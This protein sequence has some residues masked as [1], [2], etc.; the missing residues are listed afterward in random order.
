MKNKLIAVLISAVVAFGLWLYVVTVVSPESEKTYYDIPVVLQ[1]KDILSERG[2][3]I[4]S[5]EPKVTLALRS[6]RTILN[7]LNE[8]NINVIASVANI[9]K[10]GIHTLTY[11]VA[12]PGNV[13][14]N[15]VSVQSSSTDLITLEVENRVRKTVPVVI[16]FG[17]TTVPEGYIA[18]LKN[19]NLDYPTIE[20][21]GPES[22]VSKIE[23]A[24]TEKIDL[25]SQTKTLVGEYTYSL[26]DKQGDPVNA[27]KVTVNAEKINLMLKV[28]KVKQINLK[29][30]IV[31]GGGATEQNV[32]YDPMQ[33]EVSGSD[34]LLES[35]D[36]LIVGK[37]DLGEILKD[38]TLTFP[39]VLP[40]GVD[41]L[42]GVDTV[43]AE[44]KLTGLATQTF[45]V[46][47]I[48]A[49]N[50]PAGM[51]A[52]MITKALPVTV[53]GPAEMIQ[54]MKAEDLSVTVDFSGA[55]AGT[56]RVQAQVVISA[57]FP[58]VGA[59]SAYQVSAKLS[60]Q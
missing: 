54:A 50:V 24:V 7:D 10:S 34:T 21:T 33:I 43:T 53:R 58:G 35:L 28:Q 49:V 52:D 6:D 3:M 47:S 8:S 5:E 22:V 2:L 45:N 40:E 38:Q 51:Q 32:T 36:T 15:S 31:P 12:Y 4:V 59:V 48:V 14:P 25:G 37:V 1:N 9:E 16:D 57:N 44:V 29:L 30:E 13:P 56:A 17:G 26:C 39:I 20:L 19:A 27:E 11:T 23:Q 55:Q 18:D 46:T 42:T 60:E 41:N